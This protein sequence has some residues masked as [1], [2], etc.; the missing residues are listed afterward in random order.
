MPSASTLTMRVNSS[1]ASSGMAWAAAL[2]VSTFSTVWT[3]EPWRGA[4]D[5]LGLS[6][7]AGAG[8]LAVEASG[9]LAG[10]DVSG[11]PAGVPVPSGRA[12]VL[13]VAYSVLSTAA[14][15]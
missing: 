8:W 4:D 14:T 6:P 10:E 1:M 13:T 11:S 2:L 15:R 9:W 7:S 12:D 5:V 3:Y